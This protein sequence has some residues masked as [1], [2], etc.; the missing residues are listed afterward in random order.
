M[1]FLSKRNLFQGKAPTDCSCN[2]SGTI[3]VELNY[4]VCKE[5]CINLEKKFTFQYQNAVAVAGQKELKMCA[6][7][8]GTVME[9]ALEPSLGQ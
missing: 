7:G 3:Q 2:E 4:Q 1:I 5:V 8:T 9:D 6:V